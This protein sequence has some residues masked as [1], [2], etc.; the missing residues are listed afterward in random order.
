MLV[1]HLTLTMS[2]F[3]QF[4]VKLLSLP[5]LDLD[6]VSKQLELN[7]CA[8][9]DLTVTVLGSNAP[10]IASNLSTSLDSLNE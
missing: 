10:D 7:T 6:P 5:T 9:K 4:S 2:L 1:A 3:R 8:V